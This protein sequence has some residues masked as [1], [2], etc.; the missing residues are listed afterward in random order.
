M[1]EQLFDACRDGNLNRVRELIE[2]GV[3]IHTWEDGTLRWASFHGRMDVVR[4]LV[5]QGVDIHA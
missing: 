2:Q 4:Y 5:E 3:D 1:E